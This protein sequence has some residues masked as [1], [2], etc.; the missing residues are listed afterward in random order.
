MKK[1]RIKLAPI[2]GR[3]YFAFFAFVIF[4]TILGGRVYYWKTVKGAEFE[5][6][7]KEQQVNRYDVMVQANRGSIVDRNNQPFAVSTI[8]YDVILDSRVL[9]LPNSDEKT[10]TEQQEKTFAA[11]Q[12]VFP[13]LNYTELR[14]GVQIDP[15]TNKPYTDNSWK[16]LAKSVDKEIK[17][18]LEAQKLKGIYFEQTTKRTYPLK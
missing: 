2:K 7:A 17:E 16:V 6:R 14:H 12:E 3:L 11:L 5:N 8:V 15:A 18:S 13:D 4:L 9:A 10:R 1:K